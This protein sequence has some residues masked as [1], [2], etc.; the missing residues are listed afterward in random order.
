MSVEPAL[1]NPPFTNSSCRKL[2][3]GFAVYCAYTHLI[4]QNCP[5][6]KLLAPITATCDKFYIVI[7]LPPAHL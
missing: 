6:L 4:P 1:N 2:A 3:A 5:T 7:T